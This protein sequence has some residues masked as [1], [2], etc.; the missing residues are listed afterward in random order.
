MDRSY[1]DDRTRSCTY[2]GQNFFNT[3]TEESEIV[4]SFILLHLLDSYQ[5]FRTILLLLQ[6]SSNTVHSLFF[7]LETPN[8]IPKNL[9]YTFQIH[10]S[11]KFCI[12]ILQEV[13]QLLPKDERVAMLEMIQRVA[14]ETS[15]RSRRVS[16][17]DELIAD[18][19]KETYTPR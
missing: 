2:P 6:H 19:P 12:Q 18:L 13:S 1:V 16:C 8:T 14:R 4:I 7:L 3:S 11:K 15:R 17:P 9:L 10:E 5:G